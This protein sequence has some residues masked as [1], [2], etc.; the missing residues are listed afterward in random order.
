M[1]HSRSLSPVQQFTRVSRVVLCCVPW[2]LI[3]VLG[4]PI[5]THL[6]VPHSAVPLVWGA[7]VLYLAQAVTATVALASLRRPPIAVTASVTLMCAGQLVAIAYAAGP[8]GWLRPV[9]AAFTGAV[10]VIPLA[11]VWATERW[12]A[13]LACGVAAGVACVTIE[14]SVWKISVVATV[15]VWGAAGLG[16]HS[17]L[18]SLAVMRRLDAARQTESRLAVAEERLRIA[19]DVHDVLGRNLAIIAFKSELG[20]RLTESNPGAHAELTEIQ[21]ITRESQ[22]EVRD[23]V[24]GSHTTDLAT[25]LDGAAAVLESAGIA[26]RVHHNTVDTHLGVDKHVA[27]GWVIR[28]GVTNVIRHSRARSC[29]IRI[30][31]A[32]GRLTMVI[33]NDRPLEK[34]PRTGGTG[35]AGLTHRI[36][37]L[38]G[39]VTHGA[40]PKD[41]YRLTAVIPYCKD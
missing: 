16:V 35:L 17:S 22:R 1:R 37:A 15:A 4:R 41:T 27:L 12:P 5:V 31:A 33:T 20:A 19:R 32:G 10:A 39:T 8:A 26:C 18:W 14:P 30:T 3:F 25:E 23:V 28:E 40:G 2:L 36:G 7:G 11:S 38:G 21:H 13:S 29:T 6:S 34:V 24:R 9:G